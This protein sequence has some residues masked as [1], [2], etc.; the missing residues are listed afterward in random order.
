M[1]VQ[2]DYYVTVGRT[3][4]GGEVATCYKLPMPY[5]FCLTEKETLGAFQIMAFGLVIRA[6]M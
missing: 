1:T 6:E 2:V 4:W 3:R 5:L